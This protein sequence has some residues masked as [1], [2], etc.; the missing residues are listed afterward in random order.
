RGLQRFNDLGYTIGGP[1]KKDRV[2]FFFSQEYQEQL[3]PQ[4]LRKRTV[5]T[6]LERKGD[7]SQSVDSSGNPFPYIKDPLSTQP[8]SAANTA[9][10]FQDGGVVGR[11]PADRLYQPGIALLKL[12]PL[13]NAP[14][15]KGFNYLSQ[16]SDSYPR[17]EDLVKLD[18]N[19]SSKS[20]FF[21]HWL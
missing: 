3:R 2:F 19:M 1:V 11:I 9:G 14:G 12:L 21:G 16:I 15:N 20:R 5:P 4:T 18:Y 6:D 7:F 8:C 13:P 17:R 10:C